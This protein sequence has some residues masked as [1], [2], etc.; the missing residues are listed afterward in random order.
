MLDGVN[1]GAMPLPPDIRLVWN[2]TDFEQVEI[3]PDHR[4]GSTL[5]RGNRTSF[6]TW[7]RVLGDHVRM[8]DEPL[9]WSGQSHR[10]AR[11]VGWYRKREDKP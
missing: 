7:A 8:P 10:P 4:G 6:Q 5:T 2:G 3:D 9:V 1:I 11:T